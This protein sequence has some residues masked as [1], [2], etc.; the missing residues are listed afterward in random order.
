MSYIE[1]VNQKIKEMVN[2]GYIPE[3]AIIELAQNAGIYNFNPYKATET[4]LRT[5]A[6]NI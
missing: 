1:K 4:Q 3:Q 2:E 6:M 5:I